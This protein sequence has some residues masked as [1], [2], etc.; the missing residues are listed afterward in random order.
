MAESY[1]NGTF[2][3]LA[4]GTLTGALSGTSAT[5]TGGDVQITNGN[6]DLPATVASRAGVINLNG[7][8]FLHSCCS[9]ANTWIGGAGNF[10]TTGNVNTGS[11]ADALHN[12]TAGYFNTASGADALYSN[13]AGS[14]NTANGINALF[15]NDA[16]SNDVA[17][18]NCSLYN[19]TRSGASG[20]CSA[21]TPGQADA[22]T[23]IGT[24]AGLTNTTGNG[25]TFVGFGADAASGAL[26]NATAIGANAHVSESNAL[27]LGAAGTMVGIGLSAP[28][29][30]LDVAG[31]INT[32]G[33]FIG[34][35]SMLSNVTTTSLSCTACVGNTQ[36]AINY[37]ASASQGGYAVNSLELNGFS[38]SAFAMLSGPNT[39]SATQTISSGDLSVSSGDVDLPQTTSASVGAF[40][41]N[42]Q[43]FIHA[44]CSA[45]QDNTF[46]G[47]LAG[48]PVTS[49]YYNTGTGYGALHSN[50]SGG[51]NTANGT[52]A[53]YS[54]KQGQFNT[55]S[56][57]NTLYDNSGGNNNVA[58][59]ASALFFDDQGSNNVAM[60]NCSLYNTTRSGSGG[61]CSAAAPATADANTALGT[62]A[63]YSNTTG[64]LNTFV[65]FQ[66]NAGGVAAGSLTNATAI[67]AN[68]LVSASNSLV[69]GAGANVG[70]GTTTPLTA[71][72]VEG[73]NGVLKFDPNEVL[74]GILLTITGAG[75][76]IFSNEVGGDI[77]RGGGAA[78]IVF[79]VSGTGEVFADGGYQTSGADFAESVAAQGQRSQYEPGDV[80]EIDPRAD[81]RLALS[82]HAYS[83]LVAGIYSTKPG[84]LATPRAMN[85]P[86]IMNSEVPLAVVGIVPCKV[87]A[88]N[89]PIA[90]GDLLVTSSK[91]G[92][93][94]KGTDRSQMLGAVVGKAF[95][96]LPKGTGVIPVL[97]TL[98]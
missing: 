93:A 7:A 98:Q 3:P 89:G 88:E 38:S 61:S 29:H 80:L 72:D 18:G 65:G 31:D 50:T 17:V 48:T 40:K 5:F 53:L 78:G 36:L 92:Y 39:F 9:S 16:G 91:P 33:H 24:L 4:G 95:E 19:T 94:M 42:G 28:A 81:R 46:L 14:N 30:T 44:C 22:N 87:T 74:N 13:A 11:G 47:A 69:L 66:A 41:M 82:R 12:N 57:V 90:R 10:T 54:N 60:G 55:A 35:G 56:G 43:P 96:P 21:S 6:L 37:A 2:L 79:R 85:D 58:I 45:A 83:T 76:M 20:S 32:S 15:Y 34:D 77:L 97:V 1:A 63:G 71:L 25:N 75:A 86:E 64:N 23:A 84:V 73:E 51:A 70:I 52:S 68:A 26:S 67:G 62:L 8:P 49:G 59:G 27:V